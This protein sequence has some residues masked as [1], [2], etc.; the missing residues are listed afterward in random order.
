MYSKWDLERTKTLKLKIQKTGPKSVVSDFSQELT[1]S[2][3]SPQTTHTTTR[4][5]SLMIANFK[6]SNLPDTEIRNSGN[7]KRDHFLEK[8][9]GDLTLL[10]PINFEVFCPLQVAFFNFLSI[11]K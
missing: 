4:T 10:G 8:A 11:S 6:F 3:S 1:P 5:D 2:R 9:T 7:T